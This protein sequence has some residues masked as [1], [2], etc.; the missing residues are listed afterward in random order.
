MEAEYIVGTLNS[1]GVDVQ[2]AKRRRQ[3]SQQP[4]VLEGGKHRNQANAR[5]R[6]RTHRWV[7]TAGGHVC[8]L[9]ACLFISR[10]M[11]S[12]ISDSKEEMPICFCTDIKYATF[13]RVKY[14][15]TQ[16]KNFK[17]AYWWRNISCTSSE[18]L[19]NATLLIFILL[20][21]YS[22]CFI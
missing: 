8:C 6:D 13:G 9:Y 21:T 22:Q 2:G 19:R 15:W 1:D 3:M 5:E 14:F 10:D 20:T 18:V 17:F 12:D 11:P 4:L 16:C 7:K